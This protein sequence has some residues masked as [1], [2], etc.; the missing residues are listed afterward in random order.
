ME[1]APLV[2]EPIALEQPFVDGDSCLGSFRYGDRDEENISRNVA[3]DID[4][5]HA[6]FLRGGMVD[7]PSLFVAL[8]AEALRQIRSLVTARRK[9]QTRPIEVRTAAELD[10]RELPTC[11]F[12]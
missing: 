1:E 12:E 7:D 9:K 4:A 2:A 11:A 10:R 3:C 8:A 5:R 6:G